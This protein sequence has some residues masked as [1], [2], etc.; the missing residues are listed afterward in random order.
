MPLINFIQRKFEYEADEFSS[1]LLGSP[2]YMISS[3]KRIIKENLS[4]LNPLP[5]YKAWHYSH[6][7]P[8]ERIKKLSELKG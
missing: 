2:E 7:S 8:E 1:K 6:P 3:L 5:L 4:N